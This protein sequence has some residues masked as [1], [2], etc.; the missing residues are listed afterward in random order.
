MNEVIEQFCAE[1]KAWSKEDFVII[2]SYLAIGK[3]IFLMPNLEFEPKRIILEN[4]GK[5]Y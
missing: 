5:H 4:N 1:N 3:K 2:D